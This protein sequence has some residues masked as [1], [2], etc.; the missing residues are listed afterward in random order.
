[1]PEFSQIKE[2][3]ARTESPSRRNRP[4]ARD[5]FALAAVL[6][7]FAAFMVSVGIL[8]WQIVTWLKT[9]AWPAMP[10]GDYLIPLLSDSARAWIAQP[11]AWQ[12]LH[13]LVVF[14]LGVPL[15]AST[16]MVGIGLALALGKASESNS[17]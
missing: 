6:C 13:R 11:E 7:M 1:M 15:P 4:T 3:D 2:T 9:G 5:C 16:F 12:G 8:G 17:R 14:F 10:I